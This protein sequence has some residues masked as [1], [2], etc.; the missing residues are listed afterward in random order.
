MPTTFFQPLAKASVA[1]LS[2]DLAILQQAQKAGLRTAPTHVTQSACFAR[3]IEDR[4]LFADMTKNT[5]ET[6]TAVTKILQKISR[7]RILRETRLT[8]AHHNQCVFFSRK[9]TEII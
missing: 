8:L 1:T 9:G 5:L 2:A 7:S 6:T 4:E 3:L